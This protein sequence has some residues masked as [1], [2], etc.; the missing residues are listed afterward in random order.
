[1]INTLMNTINNV[2]ISTIAIIL[3]I[4]MLLISM[5]ISIKLYI[6]KEIKE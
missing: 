6:N 4:A 3:N 2:G 1:M 5:F